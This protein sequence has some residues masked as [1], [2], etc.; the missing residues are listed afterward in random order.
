MLFS[1]FQDLAEIYSRISK[2]EILLPEN[3]GVLNLLRST[4]IDIINGVQESPGDFPSDWASGIRN[5]DVI[6]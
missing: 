2:D 4:M 1:D 5:W 6:L 3:A